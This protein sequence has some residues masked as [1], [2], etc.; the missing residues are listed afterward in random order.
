M[1]IFTGATKVDLEN[2]PTVVLIFGRGLWFEDRMY[3][4]LINPNKC[5]HYG[6]PVCDDPTNNYHD[7]GLS[8]YDNLFVLMGMDGTTCGF[9]SRCTTLEEMASCK[10]ITVSH[11]TGWNTSTI[12]LNVSLV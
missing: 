11:K 1:P 5:I 6:I 12:H 4:S 9:D 8:I 7:L 3:K 10:R 2:V